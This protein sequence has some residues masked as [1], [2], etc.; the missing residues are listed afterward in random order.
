MLASPNGADGRALG[1]GNYEL[2]ASVLGTD[3]KVIVPSRALQELQR[4][5]G[6]EA[7]LTLRLGERDATFEVG[8]TRVTTRLIEGEFPNYRQLIPQSYPNLLTVQREALLEAIR[9][10]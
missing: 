8:S 6:A 5:L 4:L 7:E 10:V 1:R 3:Q 9:R 2:T